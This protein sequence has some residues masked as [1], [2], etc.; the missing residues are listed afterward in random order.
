MVGAPSPTI[1]GRVW[2]MDVTPGMGRGEGIVAAV[3]WGPDRS[4]PADN[5]AWTW[6]EADYNIDVDSGIEEGDL[7]NDEYQGSVTPTEAG[8]FDY[9]FRFSIDDGEWRYCDRTGTAADEDY[10]PEWAG[11][12]IVIDPN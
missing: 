1:Y 10:E 2:E 6:S 8:D 7:A 3:G 11:N 4:D 12:L 9:A 5:D